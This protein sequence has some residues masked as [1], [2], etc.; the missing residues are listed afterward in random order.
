M[1]RA[2]SLVELLVVLTAIS[3]LAALLLPTLERSVA[4][5]RL[6][7]CQNQLRQLGAGCVMYADDHHDR[8]PPSMIW[9]Y[10]PSNYARA[11]AVAA[12]GGVLFASYDITPGRPFGLPR[13]LSTGYANSVGTFLCPENS[14]AATPPSPETWLTATARYSYH[15]NL[16]GAHSILPTCGTPGQDLTYRPAYTR[17]SR[18]PAAKLL[19]SDAVAYMGNPTAGR[20]DHC[21]NRLH[22]DGHTSTAENP[23]IYAKY[24][25][26]TSFFP[27]GNYV[28]GCAL[29][30]NLMEQT[31]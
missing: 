20:H 3:V 5:A 8:L 15:Y 1:R 16:Y 30:F 7:A 2:F 13:L 17:L 14:A 19:A 6:L 25:Q 23:A 22:G 28:L 11:D 26:Y 18:F 12:A 10:W 9:P 31:P 4:E 21:Y 24:M 27:S 29:A